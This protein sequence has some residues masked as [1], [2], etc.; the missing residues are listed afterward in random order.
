[1]DG[2]IEHVRDFEAASPKAIHRWNAGIAASVCL[3]ILGCGGDQRPQVTGTITVDEKPAEGA[4]LLFHPKGGGATSV[5]SAVASD[6]GSYSI[7][8]DMNPGISPGTYQVT[9]TWPD[10]TFEPS[11]SAILKGIAEPGPDLLKGRYVSKANSNLEVQIEASTTQ[12][13]PITLSL[14]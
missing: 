3:L 11:K 10:P 7:V 9:V 4:I 8:S 1:M 2:L 12:L 6:D 14:P 13:D 5:G